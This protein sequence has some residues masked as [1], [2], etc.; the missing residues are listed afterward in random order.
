MDLVLP[1]ALFSK[2]HTRAG[3]VVPFVV[4]GHA[5]VRVVLAGLPD[6]PSPGIDHQPFLIGRKVH[7]LLVRVVFV[8]LPI[9]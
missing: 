2:I 5:L 3:L 9:A 4:A 1:H 6:V 8:L 7:V